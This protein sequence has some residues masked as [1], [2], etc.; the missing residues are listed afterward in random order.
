MK[1]SLDLR[2]VLVDHEM[3]DN[4]QKIVKERFHDL[5]GANQLLMR[6]ALTEYIARE[7]PKLGSRE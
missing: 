5:R 1:S 3:I 6:V 4:I 2:V 7:L